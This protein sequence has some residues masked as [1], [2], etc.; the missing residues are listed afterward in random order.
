MAA[1]GH[2]VRAA[3]GAALCLA[4]LGACGRGAAGETPAPEPAAAARP[5]ESPAPEGRAASPE[6]QAPPE[7]TAPPAEQTP[8]ERPPEPSPEPSPERS[9]ERNEEPE[10]E[11]APAASGPAPEP[12]SSASGPAPGPDVTTLTI[13]EWSRPLIRGDQSDVD[14]CREAVLFTGPE[15]GQGN[16]ADMDTSVIV[17]H[18]HCGFDLFATL[19]EGTEVVITGPRGTLRYEAY[20]HHVTPGQGGPDH[21]LYWGDITLQTCVGPDT[22]FSYLR[23]TGP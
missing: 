2:R 12:A 1:T 5:V 20:G 21:G 22:G 11:P 7:P 14:R 6:P 17:G 19:P 15:P 13:G 16:G 18:D 9:P 10:P 8:P 4:A 3:L 23:R